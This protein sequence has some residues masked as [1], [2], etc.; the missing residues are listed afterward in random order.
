MIRSMTKT[1]RRNLKTCR[2]GARRFI[3]E[4]KREK[5]IC[6]YHGEYDEEDDEENWN[7]SYFSSITEKNAIVC[8]VEFANEMK[9]QYRKEVA[10]PADHLD[11]VL[12]N[13]GPWSEAFF[14]EENRKIHELTYKVRLENG[15]ISVT[16][17]Y[18]LT[19]LRAK[20]PVDLDDT[21]VY[22]GFETE[23]PL[24]VTRGAFPGMQQFIIGQRNMWRLPYITEE[25]LQV[26]REIAQKPDYE[27]YYRLSEFEDA[28]E[29]D[30]IDNCPPYSYG[31]SCPDR[32]LS[33]HANRHIL[34]N[35]LKDFDAIVRGEGLQVENHGMFVAALAAAWYEEIDRQ[36]AVMTAQKVR[37]PFRLLLCRAGRLCGSREQDPEAIERN[38]AYRK[39][40][41]EAWETVLR[42]M[43]HVVRVEI[44]TY[45]PY[46]AIEFEEARQ[47]ILNNHVRALRGYET[48]QE[49]FKHLEPY[50]IE[51]NIDST[52]P[53]EEL[54]IPEFED[55]DLDPYWDEEDD[56]DL[57]PYWD[58]EDDEDDDSELDR[59]EACDTDDEEDDD[60]E[61]DGDETL[62]TNDEL[63]ETLDKLKELYEEIE[64]ECI[65]SYVDSLLAKEE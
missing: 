55:D 46:Y 26:S 53:S 1:D 6:W 23:M 51:I 33:Y 7:S 20:K 22:E 62:K 54:Y 39:A 37:I 45:H 11:M 19:V 25:I 5:S 10:E 24:L 61:P 44:P 35:M 56:D 47:R 48:P 27:D 15:E 36:G 18:P 29:E 49:V 4:K 12:R 14:R 63:R 41:S 17:S 57:D 30:F 64:E 50:E 58:D 38:K 9:A 31:P 59:D 40:V 65:R 43:E 60:S 13:C 32:Q 3:K 34:L 21:P 16:S 2:R 28:L 52:S 42:E 8:S